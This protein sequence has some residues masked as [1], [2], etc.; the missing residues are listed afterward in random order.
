MIKM[1]TTAINCVFDKK[2]NLE[3]YIKYIDEASAVPSQL[4]QA[5]SMLHGV[6]MFHHPQ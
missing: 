3:K 1:A 5:C 4:L 2:K 6:D